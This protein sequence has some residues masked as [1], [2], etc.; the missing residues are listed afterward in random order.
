MENNL[1]IKNNLNLE[2]INSNLIIA[3]KQ[4]K[5]LESTFGKVINEGLNLGLKAILPD[6]IEDQIIDIKDS[7]INNGFS[8][9]IKTGINSAINLGKSVIGLFTGKFE[10]IS[11]VNEAVKKG[12]L[13]DTISNLLDK[14]INSIENSGKINETTSN[15]IKKGKNTI[16][17]TINNNIENNITSQ[18]K[19][20]ENIDKYSSNWNNYYKNQDFNNMDKQFKKMEK[21]IQKVIPLENIIKTARKI[22]NI[23]N[24]IKNNG[25]NFNLS[26]E[27]IELSNKLI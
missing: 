19:S 5:F 26:K 14:G 2:N 12:G 20:I 15:L 16:L 21:E 24:L 8:A 7:L 27:E 1:E 18:I 9:A 25:N 6:V 13:I 22:E 10:N 17:N 23:H 3:D 11:Q 4:N